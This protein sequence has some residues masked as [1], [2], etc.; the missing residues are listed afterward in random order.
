MA[1]LMMVCG[2]FLFYLGIC[3]FSEM[4]ALVGAE[5]IMTGFMGVITVITGAMCFAILTEM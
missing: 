5:L 4:P 3:I 1:L 2:I